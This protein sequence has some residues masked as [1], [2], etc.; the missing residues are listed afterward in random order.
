MLGARMPDRADRD[1]ASRR[2]PSAAPAPGYPAQRRW[3]H[4][5]P[6]SAAPARCEAC[7]AAPMPGQASAPRSGHRDEPEARASGPSACRGR[8]CTAST[9]PVRSP[10]PTQLVR[11]GVDAAVPDVAAVERHVTLVGWGLLRKARCDEALGAPRRREAASGGAEARSGITLSSML[12]AQRSPPHRRAARVPITW[13]TV[14]VSDGAP[15]SAS[16]AAERDAACRRAPP[17]AIACV[18]ESSTRTS[19][20]SRPPSRPTT[21]GVAR[22][23]R[24]ASAEDRRSQPWRATTPP[25]PWSLPRMT[26][27]VTASSATETAPRRHVAGREKRHGAVEIWTGSAEKDGKPSAASGRWLRSE[28]GAT[29]RAISDPRPRPEVGPPSG[30]PCRLPQVNAFRRRQRVGVGSG[31]GSAG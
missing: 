5:R 13:P 16:N 9:I 23:P 25:A 27:R 19:N 1:S 29:V 22:T 31:S 2:S 11:P 6:E 3:S 20:G 15:C 24:P 18:G 14:H 4:R 28:H 8:V 21:P 26:R 7:V 12:S 17:N 10:Q 30:A